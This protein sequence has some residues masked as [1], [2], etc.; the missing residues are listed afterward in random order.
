MAPERR[1]E[2]TDDDVAR[3]TQVLK[4][5]SLGKVHKITIE[6][7]TGNIIIGRLPTDF[8][9]HHRHAE[10]TDGWLY[11]VRAGDFVKIGF[12]KEVADRL[13]RLQTGSPVKLELLMAI[14][15]KASLE[16]DFHRK[17]ASLR[18]HGEWFKLDGALSA[19][20]DRFCLRQ[21]REMAG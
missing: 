18:A 19:Y 6:A 10:N 20:L 21:A 11:F 17:F 4:D 1:R 8:M 14:E 7:E 15:G 12:A 5:R 2:I 16:R 13:P 3:L 9:I